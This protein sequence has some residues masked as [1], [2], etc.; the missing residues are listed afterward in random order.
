M[1]TIENG[2]VWD[3]NFLVRIGVQGLS[4]S[5]TE[6]SEVMY[7]SSDRSAFGSIPWPPESTAIAFGSWGERAKL[8]ET[9]RRWHKAIVIQKLYDGIDSLVVGVES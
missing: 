8:W 4:H 9:A 1:E 2:L 7:P 3:V 5:F 6:D